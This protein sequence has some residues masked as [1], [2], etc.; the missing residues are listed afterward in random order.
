MISQCKN[1]FI[2]EEM[3]TVDAAIINHIT[4]GGGSS[5]GGGSYTAG[6]AID[7]TNNAISVK[8][9][10]NTMEIVDGKLSAKTGGGSEP[11]VS[12]KIELTKVHKFT[13]IDD[14]S[15]S[16]Q[17][18]FVYVDAERLV[19][20]DRLRFYKAGTQETIDGVIKDVIYACSPTI[21]YYGV[22]FDGDSRIFEIDHNPET[23]TLYIPNY[24]IND[25]QL[26][27]VAN[28][29]KLGVFRLTSTDPVVSMLLDRITYVSE[30]LSDAQNKIYVSHA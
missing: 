8:F 4:N 2:F 17:G 5:G 27:V 21:A 18:I 30:S 1:R 20:G 15:L 7:L 22:Q 24:T 14:V 9:N 3:S 23:H 26:N 25:N 10:T 11:I 29:P 19:H 12:P 28:D 13:G 6:T 16:D